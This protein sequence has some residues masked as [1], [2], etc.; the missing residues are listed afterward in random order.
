MSN[1][2]LPE[3]KWRAVRTGLGLAV[4]TAC[5]L[6]VSTS[7]A[8]A[9]FAQHHGAA[10]GRAGQSLAADGRCH[11]ALAK[12]D[13]AIRVRPTDAIL[14][15]DRGRCHLELGNEGPA[16]TDFETYL[17]LAPSAPDAERIR[18]LLD[19]LGG[20]S[21][22]DD[23][24]SASEVTRRDANLK[25]LPGTPDGEGEDEG[26]EDGDAAGFESTADG[27][28]LLGPVVAFRSWPDGEY[29]EETV[30]W[31]IIGGYLLGPDDEVHA[32]LTKL[33][34]LGFADG[35]NISATYNH[36]VIESGRF[37]GW[38]GGGVAYD[39]QTS[40]RLDRPLYSLL[41]HPTVRFAWTS[42]L[43]VQGGLEAA[44]AYAPAPEI[45]GG[46]TGDGGAVQYWAPRLELVWLLGSGNELVDDPDSQ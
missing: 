12:F 19:S 24:P 29:P 8:A 25:V 30:Q 42:S 33:Q 44:Y 3:H 35:F 2:L 5:W 34:T 22:H 45:A 38:I 14:I 40:N 16:R 4:T 41:L 15:R 39:N 37:Q 21:P 32:R 11:E 27:L 18:T 20:Y 17:G 6:G 28:W 46:G 9:P 1:R 10:D 43:F 7:W 26:F 23:D 13:E 31:G 36:A